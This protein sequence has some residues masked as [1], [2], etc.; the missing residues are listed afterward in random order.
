MPLSKAMLPTKVP[1]LYITPGDARLSG[2]EGELM[3]EA[4]RAISFARCGRQFRA[5]S[6]LN[7]DYMLIDC[8]P[9]LNVLTVNAL[10]AAD[11]V[12][13][14]LQRNTSRSKASRN[15]SRPSTR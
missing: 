5:E 4:Q 7:I 12:L 13:V 11:G 14:P 9:S 3:G 1:S 10:T 15:W 6:Q 8:P 2:V